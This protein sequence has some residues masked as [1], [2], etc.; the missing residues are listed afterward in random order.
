MNNK[1]DNTD[2]KTKRE[3]RLYEPIRQLLFDIF[4]CH[5][6]EKPKKYQFQTAPYKGEE[7]PYLE[8][9]GKKRRF[10]ET[11]KRQF[12]TNTLLL[13][14]SEGSFPDIVGYVQKKP[15]NPIEIIVAEI[16]DK[17]IKLMDI[18]QARLYQEIFN[19]SLCFLI[20]S[21]DIVEER[22]RFVRDREFIRGKVIVAQYHENP[23]QKF[24]FF[25]IHPIFKAN[26]PEAFKKFCIE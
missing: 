22:M 23:Y 19:P 21:E 10:S 15:S 16:K 4:S 1:K 24:G 2:K 26:V 14:N 9:V 20:S 6:I 18:F 5:Y 17:P 12:T 7:N 11:L 25:N 3:E 13:I 8:I